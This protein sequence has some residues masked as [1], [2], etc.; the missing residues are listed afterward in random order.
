MLYPF[1]AKRSCFQWEEEV[2]AIVNIA[3]KN[4]EKIAH[5]DKGCYVSA[6]LQ[7][8][9]ESVWLHPQSGD[10][11]RDQVRAVLDSHGF[12]HVGIYKSKWDSLPYSA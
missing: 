12:G 4:Q 7:R 9:V 8:L 2:R 11:F 1:F 6:D 5:S 3:Q 10:K